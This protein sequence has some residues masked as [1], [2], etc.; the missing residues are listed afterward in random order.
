MYKV[1]NVYQSGNIVK[2]L[3][4]LNEIQNAQ[5]YYDFINKIPI[6]II[7]KEAAEIVLQILP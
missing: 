1:F 7:D 3:K 6:K 5:I 4:Y 2:T